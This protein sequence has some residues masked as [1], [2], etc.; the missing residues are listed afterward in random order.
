MAG[1]FSS[2]KTDRYKRERL[3]SRWPATIGGHGRLPCAI[4]T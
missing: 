1:A 3:G 2:L 4:E